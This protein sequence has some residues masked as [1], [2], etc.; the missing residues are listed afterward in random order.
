[1]LKSRFFALLF[2]LIISVSVFAQGEIRIQGIVE[3]YGKKADGVNVVLYKNNK[4]FKKITTTSNG[5]FKFDL[6]VNQQYLIEVSKL[7]HATIKLGFDTHFPEKLIKEGVE[8]EFKIKVDIVEKLEGLDLSILDQPIAIVKFLQKENR[9]DYDQQYF[10]SIKAKLQKLYDDVD[11]LLEQGAKPLPDLSPAEL[12]KKEE[13]KKAKEEAARKA[14]EEA[15]L[16]VAEEAKRKEKDEQQRKLREEEDKQKADEKRKLKLEEE[17][18]TREAALAEQE[19]NEK[20]KENR[21]DK[22]KDSS[23]A[24]EKKNANIS[25]KEPESAR[26][27][28][29]KEARAEEEKRNQNIK[30]EYENELLKMAAENEKKQKELSYAQ[31]KGETELNA[32]KE[33]YEQEEKIKA[34]AYPIIKETAEYNKKTDYNRQVKHNT[35]TSLLETVAYVEKNKKSMNFKENVSPAFFYIEV[36]PI[37]ETIVSE[38]FFKTTEKTIVKKFNQKE[39]LLKVKYLW[40]ST[41]YYLNGKEINEETYKKHLL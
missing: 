5:K 31:Q 16:K 25:L 3:R 24:E 35:M 13:D 8:G 2:F 38:D 10:N 26:I 11:K 20:N 22:V 18:K 34:S 36:A 14:K 39:E 32:I 15:D 19:K 27:A 37:L 30:K 41:Y 17:R 40:G 29:E 21:V 23:V 1:M 6:D 9:F 28:K 33:K 12:A 4:E 7:Q